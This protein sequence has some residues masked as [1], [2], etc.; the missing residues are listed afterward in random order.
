MRKIS[1]GLVAAVLALALARPARG[2]VAITLN[3]DRPEATLADGLQL[4]VNVS[5]AHGGNMR[6]TI[7]GVED[8]VLRPAGAST[9]VEIV[10]GRYSAGMEFTYLLQPK[11]AGSLRVGPAELTVDGTTYRSN[12]ATLT[13]VAPAASAAGDRGPVFLV[14]DLAPS[15]VYLEQQA[16]YTLRLYRLVNVGEASVSVPEVE[17]VAFS[18]LGDPREYKGVYQGRSYQVIEL[19]YLLRAQKAGTFTLPPARMDLTVFVPLN[20][21]RRGI[22]DDPFFAQMASGRPQSLASEA[23]PLEVLPLP[24]EGR[25]ADYSGLVGSFTVTS[26]IEPQVIKAGESVTMTVTVRGRGNVKRIP[27]LKFPPL[28]GV[29][30]Y[31]DQPV[32]KEETGV[33]GVAGYRTIKWALVPEREGH[34]RIP[35]LA[36]SYFDTDAGRYRTLRTGEA[37]LTVSPGSGGRT[38][39]V[40]VRTM[41]A[42]AEVATKKAVA[43]VGRD[44]LPVRA[45]AG[46]SDGTASA[47]PSGPAFWVLLAG[48]PAAFFL[49]LGGAGFRR[50]AGGLTAARKARKAA[51]GLMQACGRNGQT[52]DGLM[53]ALQE[54]VNLRLGLSRG[55]ITAD[56]AA[57]VFRSRNLDAQSVTDL[58]RV[59]H[60]LEDAIYTGRGR[61]AIDVGEELSVIV[62]RIEKDLRRG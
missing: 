24:P 57:A 43:E 4:S 58:H 16:L 18:K 54:Y 35:S 52:A 8:F 32:Q 46:E 61:Q 39:P 11:R 26:T 5:G 36:L 12:V 45:I 41:G 22:F 40:Q 17:G 15:K 6:P 49:T 13:V 47:A 30:I 2:E 9:K 53:F 7:R 34:Y 1:L 19:R 48:P 38:E 3:L 20:R 14:A 23:L 60:A 50:R 55:S 56:E 29:K 37:T 44:I 21:P 33:D 59:W 51:A 10:N 42:G 27:E 25:P 62:A 31:A 28:D